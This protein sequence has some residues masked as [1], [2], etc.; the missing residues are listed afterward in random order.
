M[1]GPEERLDHVRGDL[2]QDVAEE[3]LKRLRHRLRAHDDALNHPVDRL[4]HGVEDL[5]HIVMEPDELTGLPANP[6][7]RFGLLALHGG[8]FLQTEPEELEG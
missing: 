2:R 1:H 4:A 5:R 8:Q 3:V 6:G 7:Q